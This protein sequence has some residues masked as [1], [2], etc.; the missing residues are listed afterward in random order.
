MRHTHQK[1]LQLRLLNSTTQRINNNIKTVK[2]Q[3]YR[4]RNQDFLKLKIYAIH[5]AKSALVG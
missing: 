5:V 1:L 4:F 2:Q 3:A